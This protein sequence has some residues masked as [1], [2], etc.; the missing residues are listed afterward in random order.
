MATFFLF[1]LYN[2]NAVMPLYLPQFP[3]VNSPPEMVK[4]RLSV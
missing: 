2:L 1:I 4:V 3:E